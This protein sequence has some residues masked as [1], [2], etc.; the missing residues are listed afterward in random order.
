MRP[1]GI[2][3]MCV[4]GLLA[5]AANGQ[6][7]KP[8]LSGKWQANAE[9]SQLH[10]GNASA[11]SLSIEQKGASI[12]VV[13]TTKAANGK[14]SV[15]EFTCTTDGKDC[16]AKGVKVYLWYEGDSLV[17]MD[18]NGALVIRTSMTLGADANSISAIVTYISPKAEGDKFVLEKI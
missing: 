12:H 2:S 18:V 5:A 3:F 11:L 10:S 15:V 1:A 14:E 9:K 17:E 16:D 13:K 6:Q 4:F 7:S 8:N